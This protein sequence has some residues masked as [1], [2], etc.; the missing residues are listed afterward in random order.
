MTQQATVLNN[1]QI[2][3]IRQTL[4]ADGYGLTV[5]KTD[6]GVQ[7]TV[8][9]ADNSCDDCLVPKPILATMLQPAVDVPVEDIAIT[10]PGE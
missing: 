10:Y 7:V 9:S 6:T 4:A 2:E 5:S 3:Q 1:D 8:T